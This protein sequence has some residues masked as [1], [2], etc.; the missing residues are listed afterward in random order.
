MLLDMTELST[1]P[2]VAADFAWITVPVTVERAICNRNFTAPSK[3]SN[4]QSVANVISDDS[5]SDVQSQVA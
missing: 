4:V 3:W 5:V 1:V 2:W